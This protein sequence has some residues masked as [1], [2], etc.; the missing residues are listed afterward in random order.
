MSTPPDA[1]DRITVDGRSLELRRIS[2]L[3]AGLPTLVFLHEGIGSVSLWR[4]FPDALAAA[5][6]CE[7]VVYSRYGYGQSD[8]LDGPRTQDYMHHEALVVLPAL[9]AQL[10]VRHP[11]PVGHSDGASIALMFA[12]R[13][14]ETH[15][16]VVEAPHVFVEDEAIAGIRAAKVAWETTDLRA[17]LARHHADPD[18][19]FAGW[20]DTWLE[21]SF[22]AWNIEAFL[23]GIRCPVLAIQGFDDEYGTMAQPDAVARQVSGP[24]EVL[25]LERCGHSPHR[26]RFED[27]R[28]AIARFVAA[29]PL[30]ARTS[31]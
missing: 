7:A 25:R 22:R 16:V 24:C 13:H 4:D 30:P 3:R 1:P 12:A 28:D 26:D 2:A 15:A 20:N 23:P 29:H 6:G 17:R 9:L 5:T 10:G 8:V 14:P 27:V 19:T 18:R 21:P 31:A 11:L